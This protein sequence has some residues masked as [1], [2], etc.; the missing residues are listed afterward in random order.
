MEDTNPFLPVTNPGYVPLLVESYQTEAPIIRR[1]KPFKEQLMVVAGML[2]TG[3]SK[4]SNRVNNNLQAYPWD[5]SMLLWQRSAFHFQ[6]EK[7]WMNGMVSLLLPIQS[8][9]V[10]WGNMVWV[11]AV[12]RDL[13]NWM[14]L[15]F[16]MVADEWY[17]INGFWTGS[18]TTLPNSQVIML[19]TGSTNDSVRT[20]NLAYPA[21]PSDPLLINWIKYSGIALVY[22]TNDFKNYTIEGILYAVS[23]PG[24]WECVDLYPEVESLRVS[25]TDFGKVEVKAGETIPLDVGLANQLDIIAEFEIDKEALDK[26]AETDEKFSCEKSGGAAD[27]GALGPFGILVLAE[28]TLTEQTP[29][30]FYIV[31]GT[32]GTFRTFFCTDNSR[33]SKATDVSKQIYGGF[34]RVPESEKMSMRIL[35]DIIQ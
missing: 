2:A 33:S 25:S 28:E 27:R 22:N 31:K 13:I 10:V 26:A 6:P 9:G 15:P 24:M 35:V 17:D 12:S 21:N 8:K 29:V 11:H 32:G 14:H 30:Y 18:A 4:K 7:N 20:Q 3:V 1:R 19:Y 34:V 16:A 5:I 23:G